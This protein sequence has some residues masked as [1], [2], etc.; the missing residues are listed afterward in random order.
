MELSSKQIESVDVI[1]IQ[2]SVDALTAGDVQRYFETII[3]QGNRKLI[4]DLQGVDFMSSAG[5]RAIMA[6][7]KNVR[8]SGGDLRLA[9]PQP[10]IAKMLKI[11]GFT[12]ILKSYSSV[13]A[14]VS[15]YN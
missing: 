1:S 2:G 15:S 11:S 3:S 4:A 12:S 7:S 10:S 13:D 14:A 5:L 9:A 8:Q 6:V